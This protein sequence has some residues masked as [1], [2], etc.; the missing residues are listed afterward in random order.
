MR[1]VLSRLLLACVALTFAACES[2]D[3]F[4]ISGVVKD[5]PADVLRL[6]QTSLSGNI[7]LDSLELPTSGKFSFKQK[8]A[9]FPD[10][11]QL[12]LGSQRFVFVVDST[13]QLE[14]ELDAHD[15]VT[16]I[17]IRGSMKTEQLAE[18]RYSLLNSSLQQHRELQK[19]IILQDPRSMV[20]YFALHQTKQGQYILNPYNE[21]DL[22]Y[23][24]AV[25]T[26]FN[27]FM[28]DY[29][30]SKALYNQVLSVINEEKAAASRLRLQQMIDEA[31]NA[32]LDIS[33]P[34]ENG[35][36]ASLSQFLGK[37]IVLDFSAVQMPQSTGYIFELR[38]LY[39][40]YHSRG[41]EIYSV[42][43]DRGKLLW[44]QTA[45]NLPW[46]TVRSEIGIQDKV[47]LT[48]NVQS[49]PTLFLIDRNGEI[50][51]R[52]ADF[53]ELKKKIEQCL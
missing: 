24:R 32:F 6:E 47:Y 1:D 18:L 2:A 30:R 21:D 33:L 36:V 8:R 5:A 16:P 46:T 13:E 51:G 50:V 38:E 3:T 35:V 31:D 9:D 49:L 20:A 41:L 29:Y 45:E 27:T 28:P 26:S 52:F 10:I 37:V 53:S 23:F 39:N 22:P 7:V 14:V 4:Q 44:Q 48:Y 17:S 15:F 12:R 11:Y 42:S 34:D 43:A 40:Q 25:A 19:N